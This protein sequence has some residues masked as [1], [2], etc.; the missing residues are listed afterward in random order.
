VIFFFLALKVFLVIAYPLYRRGE[1]VHIHGLGEII[2]DV[3]LKGFKGVVLIGGD[4]DDLGHVF[5]VFQ[6]LQATHFGHLYIQENEVYLSFLEE[7]AGFNGIGVTAYELKVAHFIHTVANG[8][9]LHWV[10]IYYYALYRGHRGVQAY[11]FKCKAKTFRG[12]ILKWFGG[13]YCEKNGLFTSTL[14]QVIDRLIQSSK[15]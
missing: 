12:F 13:K 2:G 15:E 10:I 7:E 1:A 9:A 8:L 14:L 5:E 11:R 4:H 6:E 3:K